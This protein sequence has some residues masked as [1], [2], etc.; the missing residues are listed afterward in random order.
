[1]RVRWRGGDSNSYRIGYEGAIDLIVVKQTGAISE[2]SSDT[3]LL[4]PG[5]IPVGG[6]VALSSTY[7]TEDD[8]AEGP[9]N[10][11]DYGL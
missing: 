11:Y 3:S 8:A 6:Y 1:M 2:S 7:L 5:R 9:L 10:P 4:P